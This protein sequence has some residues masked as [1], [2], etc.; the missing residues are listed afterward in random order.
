MVLCP[1]VYLILRHDIPPLT[2]QPTEVHSAHWVPVRVLISSSLST[3]ER[4]DV[5]ERLARPGAGAMRFF[6]RVMFGQMM[7]A[8]THLVPTES[9]FCS[10]V[11]DFLPENRRVV[12]HG[13]SLILHPRSWLD[14]KLAPDLTQQR[15]MV[16]WG[17]TL[18]MISDFLESLP[19]DGLSKFWMWPTFT[20]WDL[21]FAVWLFS[22][23][24]RT[25]KLRDLLVDPKRPSS[26]GTVNAVESRG[27]DIETFSAS[28]VVL[29]RKVSRSSTVHNMLD[30]YFD[31]MKKAV[32]ATLLFR[33]GVGT[34]VIVLMKRK[35]SGRR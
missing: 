16:L 3:I 29:S 11:P 34:F 8:A 15:P 27:L 26:G 21:Q 18:G 2:L 13:F 23:S 9:L 30:G 10:S 17:L 7:F 24:F 6:L 1:F 19:S 25:R 5:S 4:C 14:E 32:V 22:Y 35:L 31:V 33:L 28:D 20:P 12:P